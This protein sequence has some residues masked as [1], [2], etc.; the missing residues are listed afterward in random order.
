MNYDFNFIGFYNSKPSWVAYDN[1][2]PLTIRWN[3]N[4]YWEMIGWEGIFCGEPRSN[5][6]DSFPDTGWYIYDPNNECSDASFDV[7]IGACP[8]PGIAV[9]QSCCD[10]NIVIRVTDIPPDLFPFSNNSYYLQSLLF[11]GCVTEVDPST[12]AS[13]LVQ[14]DQLTEQLGGCGPCTIDYP[15]ETPTPT[16]Q[17]VTPTPTPTPVCPICATVGT[18]PNI[19]SSTVING[20]TITASGFGNI[21]PTT[22]SGVL[23]WCMTPPGS[24]LNTIFLGS[25]VGPTSFTYILTF[26]SPVNNIVIRLI[27]Y[28]ITPSGAESFTFTTNTGNPVLSSCDYCCATING[29]VV[30]ATYCPS[31]SPN[32]QDGGGTFTISNPSPFTTLTISGPGGQAG[33]VVD[34]CSDSVIPPPPPSPTPTVTPTSPLCDLNCEV[35]CGPS[36]SAYNETTCYTITS[37][38]STAPTAP[39][40]LVPKSYFVYSNSGTFV[41]NPNYTINGFVS[42]INDGQYT[43]IS[44]PVLWSNTLSNLTDGPLNRCGIWNSSNTPFDTWVGFSTCLD[45]ELTKTYY[46]GLGA[47]NHFKLVLD[48]ITIVNTRTAIGAWGTRPFNRWNVYPITI[49]AGSHVLELYGWNNDGVASFG[50]E[51]Y[52]NTLS[53][54]VNASTINDINI[55]F[56]SSGITTANVVQNSNDEYLPNGYTCPDGYVYNFCTN[57]CELFEFCYPCGVTPTPT[58]TPTLTPQPPINVD[59]LP[60][61][62]TRLDVT[63]PSSVGL[64]SY[65]PTLNITTLLNLPQS[66]NLLGQAMTN[67]S[68]KLWII[69]DAG[70]GIREWD[71]TLNPWT[72]VWS[73]DISSPSPNSTGWLVGAAC[74]YRDP[75]TN[76]VNPNLLVSSGFGLT[77]FDIVL[78]D[79]SGSIWSKTTLYQ[80]S[81]LSNDRQISEV[82]MNSNG[83]MITIGFDTTTN[84]KYVTQFHYVGGSW[85]VQIDIPIPITTYIQSFFQW[86]NFFYIGAFTGELYTIQTSPPYTTSYLG[87]FLQIRSFD[88]GQSPDC[89]TLEFTVPSV[90]PTTTP[91]PTVTP[92]DPPPTPSITPTNTLTP[93]VT[94]TTGVPCL[95]E[96]NVL[97]NS[98]GNIYLYDLASN[99]TTYLNPY[100]I[101][102]IGGSAD[103]AHTSNKIFMYTNNQIYEYDYINC[104]FSASFNRVINIPHPVILGNGLTAINN[105]TLI[106]SNGFSYGQPCIEIDITTTNASI[107]TLFSFTNRAIQGDLM[108]TTSA[109]PKLLATLI[110]ALGNKYLSQYDYTTFNLEVDININSIGFALGLFA[111]NNQIYIGD[112]GGGIWSVNS[113]FPYN[114]TLIQT[115]VVSVGGASSIPECS[116]V[117]LFFS[118]T[119]PTPTPTI[120]PTPTVTPTDPPPTPTITPTNTKTPTITPTNTPTNTKT[121]TPTVTPTNPI[122]GCCPEDNTLPIKDPVIL[123]GV[124]ITPSYSGSVSQTLSMSFVPSCG[125]SPINLITPL[126]FGQNSFTYSLSFSNPVNN[127]TIRLVNYR[128]TPTG[129]DS[130]TFTTNTGIPVVSS[131]E[132]CCANIV[133]N[134]V[135]AAQDLTNVFCNSTFGIGSGLFTITSSTPFTSLTISG[136]GN[137]S[138]AVYASICNFVAVPAVTPTPTPTI[139]PTMSRTP[140][141]ELLPYLARNCCTGELRI[142]NLPINFVLGNVIVGSDFRC[143][144][145]TGVQV[146]TVNLGWGGTTFT[147][148]TSCLTE[149]PCTTPTPTPTNTKTPTPTVTKTPTVT[150]TKT[151]IPTITPTKTVTPTITKTKTPTP[152]KTPTAT[153]T[154]FYYRIV[155]GNT[156]KEVSITF[157]PC[158][159]TEISPLIIAAGGA[160]SVCSSTPPSLPVGV[161]YTLLGNCP[162][163]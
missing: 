142:V 111:E 84:Q 94:P 43:I 144:T 37:I 138:T 61:I 148:C 11:N 14:Y 53:D 97:L 151:P 80:L 130:F 121:P 92:T 113:S 6:N 33:T 96:C 158:C 47:D 75:I 49:N 141:P 3:I 51:I 100:I 128:Y 77:G 46:V 117:E 13:V 131:C 162:T 118:G 48:G 73:R 139:T 50:C 108:Y 127:V 153:P 157:T 109:Q 26:S 160:A 135:T 116:D 149:L 161:T 159:V 64:Y 63:S 99:T 69:Q 83:K 132:Y 56:S 10:S 25:G 32:P 18:L 70:N 134:V 16:P 38:P 44:T 145:I 76:I 124:T 105:T 98:G 91:T 15:C 8:L 126:L 72:A 23:S 88:S 150:P 40:T 20:V 90:T 36:Y 60:L 143:Y 114:V 21:V 54:L 1:A 89:I 79:I 137:G 146:G 87:N 42:S 27:N 102:P 66:L 62:M 9:F 17:A 12:P 104:P 39:Y 22:F 152:T 95:D 65:N 71:I 136:P 125:S 59:C 30:T 74:V 122:G 5:D 120:T 45:V 147:G 31:G 112:G 68:N 29:N 107:T 2:T 19:G 93:T 34:I 154:C 101:G 110:D 35:Q 133:G 57:T 156:T 103:I 7:T 86:N 67:T 58:P 4:G 55:I 78:V 85:Q 140:E 119:T 115:S 123:N 28:S 106:S 81:N 163:C 41:Y 52:D 82:V 155:N 24:A 129:T